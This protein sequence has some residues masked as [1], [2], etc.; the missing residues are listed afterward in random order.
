MHEHR[1]KLKETDH[2]QGDWARES[3]VDIRIDH[4]H[5]PIADAEKDEHSHAVTVGI[6]VD[7]KLV[8]LR[9]SG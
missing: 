2:V 7:G 9:R 6:E 5:G 1:I 4:D 8:T 3:Y